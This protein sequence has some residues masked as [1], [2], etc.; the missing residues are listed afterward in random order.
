MV[1]LKDTAPE[2]FFW[3]W[4]HLSPLDERD[5]SCDE[6]LIVEDVEVEGGGLITPLQV[7]GHGL[8]PIAFALLLPFTMEHSES[9]GGLFVDGGIRDRLAA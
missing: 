2:A 5:V 3:S 7:L 8:R 6:P 9:L 1:V 4:D